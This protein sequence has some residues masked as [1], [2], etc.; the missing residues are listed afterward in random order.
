MSMKR[1][2][3]LGSLFSYTRP[4]E[5]TPDFPNLL[6][7]PKDLKERLVKVSS[8]PSFHLDWHFI[9]ML[10]SN[11]HWLLLLFVCFTLGVFK[12]YFLFFHPLSP[13]SITDPENEVDT[14]YIGNLWTMWRSQQSGTVGP[15]SKDI[16]GREE[17][18][19]LCYIIKC[20][21]FYTSLTHYFFL[22]TINNLT[23]LS[24]LTMMFPY[25]V[26]KI[27]KNLESYSIVPGGNFYFCNKKPWT[28]TEKLSTSFPFPLKNYWKHVTKQYDKY[29]D[30]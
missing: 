22:Y 27:Y 9:K 14:Q 2:D 6:Y 25:N 10:F 26:C 12:F 23:L 4:S 11:E 24:F 1:S 18:C 3:V 29:F 30:M 20:F 28:T 13:S 21:K 19:T 16:G 17:A 15:A 7:L 8:E 5:V